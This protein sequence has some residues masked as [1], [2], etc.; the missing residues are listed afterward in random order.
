MIRVRLNNNDQLW[1][2]YQ[3][4]RGH[5]EVGDGSGQRGSCA[6]DPE[7]L[8]PEQRSSAPPARR[9]VE[10]IRRRVAHARARRPPVRS[11]Q[12]PGSG[13]AGL[14][15]ACGSD[16]GQISLS[17]A[18]SG[19]SVSP[20]AV[21]AGA[22]SRRDRKMNGNASAGDQPTEN[23]RARVSPDVRRTSEYR[24]DDHTAARAQHRVEGEDRG[25]LLGRDQPVQVRLSDGHRG[26]KQ[27]SPDHDQRATAAQNC[28]N[29]PISTRVTAL[30][31]R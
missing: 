3:A 17:S 5:C 15:P 22:F 1:H 8:R 31:M 13:Q 2:L 29:T 26:R 9:L 25:A 30:R 11:E 19:A 7:R 24:L 21:S 6:R 28:S 18:A 20:P 14:S 4:L 16:P 23:V 10:R 12:V 27:Q